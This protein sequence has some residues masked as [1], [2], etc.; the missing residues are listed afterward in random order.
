MP[1]YGLRLWTFWQDLSQIEDIY[2]G[3]WKSFLASADPRSISTSTT[4]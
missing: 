3:A 1:G 2:G 4:R